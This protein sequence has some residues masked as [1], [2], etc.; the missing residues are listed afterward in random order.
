MKIPKNTIHVDLRNSATI[1]K[2]FNFLLSKN[3]GFRLLHLLTRLQKGKQT[4]GLQNEERFI[5]SRHHGPDIRIRIYKPMNT[6]NKLP[7]FLYFHGGG[8]ALG[9]PEQSGRFY[10]KLIEKRPC[11]IVAPDYRKSLKAPYPA[12]FEDCYD[13]LL[14][15][16]ENTNLLN[17]IEN[18]I[19]VGGHSAGGGL[20]AAVTLKATET[21]L[22]KIAFQM[23]FYPMIDDRQ[24]TS[25]SKFISP[26]WGAKSNALGW[27]LYL[28]NYELQNSDD[29]PVY[30]APARNNNYCNFPPTITFVGDIEPFFD[31]TVQYVAALKKFNIPVK[32]KIY[33]GCFH[34]F[35]SFVP[36]CEIAKDAINFTYNS[37]AEYY[38]KY[39]V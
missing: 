11:I 15:I 2:G 12:A 37:Y 23:P 38:D 35:E 16:N 39:I 14:W 31:E 26:V 27:K 17:A 25:S 24:I 5:K 6:S 30:A 13:T 29:I 22:V 18:K 33:K 1:L 20:T 28:K 21:Q 9:C 4:K 32:F 10:K 7:V 36:Q 34:A 19:I 8:Y 3:W